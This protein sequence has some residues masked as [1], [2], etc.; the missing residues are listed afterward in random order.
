MTSRRRT[1]AISPVTDRRRLTVSH[2]S[3]ERYRPV[4]MRRHVSCRVT[5]RTNRRLVLKVLIVSVT[6][7]TRSG[8]TMT[9][10]TV[11]NGTAD[12]PRVGAR[13]GCTHRL[14]RTVVMTQVRT[15]A[16]RR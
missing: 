15:A 1:V 3:T 13:P 6:Q 2:G 12:A 4:D 5:L 8:V 14:A 16:I 9:L 11:G 10:S 7:H